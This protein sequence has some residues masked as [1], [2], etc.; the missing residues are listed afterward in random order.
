MKSTR[1]IAV[2]LLGTM[3][4][5]L[6]TVGCGK[7]ENADL[8]NEQNAEQLVEQPQ[9]NETDVQNTEEQSSVPQDVVI[10][11]RFGNLAFPEQ[12]SEFITTNETEV[13]D[14]CIKV[15]FSAKIN[16][17]YYLLFTIYIG[18]GEGI[19]E[20]VKVGEIRDSENE[21]RNVYVEVAEI[22]VDENL[23]EGEQNRIYAMQE[24]LNYLIDNLK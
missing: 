4:M 14:E 16:D 15:D 12:W 24:D 17:T 7:K 3:L 19:D 2:L 20:C 9:Q 1:K 23:S 6:L 18:N 13:S 8:P 10:E 21:V 5:C 22:T 11:T